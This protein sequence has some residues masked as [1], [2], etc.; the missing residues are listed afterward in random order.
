MSPLVYQIMGYKKQIENA[1]CRF[2]LPKEIKGQPARK[3][4]QAGGKICRS[5]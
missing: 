1:P 5:F 2:K 3:S 4:R